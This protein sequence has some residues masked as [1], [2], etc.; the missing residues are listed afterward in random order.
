VLAIIN[1]ASS[2]ETI[3]RW[4]AYQAACRDSLID[5]LYVPALGLTDQVAIVDVETLEQDRKEL[6][7]TLDRLGAESQGWVDIGDFEE[8]TT[9]AIRAKALHDP[10]DLLMVGPLP[11]NRLVNLVFGSD[12]DGADADREL[13]VVVVPRSAWSTGVPCAPPSRVTVGFHGSPPATAALDW[14][15][16]EA[17]RRN[18]V[19]GAVMAWCEGDYGGL[20]GPVIIEASDLSRLSRS[21]HE[22]AADSLSSCGVQ[23]DRVNSIARRGMPASILTKEAAGSDLLAVGAGRSTVYG[24]RTLGAVT[25]ACLI[26]SPVPVVIVPSNPAGDDERNG[27]GGDRRRLMLRGSGARA[28]AG[29][30][31]HLHGCRRR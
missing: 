25:M 29:P 12:P 3:L 10:H 21:A 1:D 15:V 14:A 11:I 30:Q 8:T 5:V 27:A 16:A 2:A 26:R 17:N 7:A 4:C 31:G 13:T 23:T 18:G 19:V 28:T 9:E 6:L 22:L 24:H 20:G